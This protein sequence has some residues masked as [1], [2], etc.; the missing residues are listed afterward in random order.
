[1][2][3]KHVLSKEVKNMATASIDFTW[4]SADEKHVD[5]GVV[6]MRHMETYMGSKVWDSGLK[7]N[8]LTIIEKLRMKHCHLILSSKVNGADFAS[9]ST[10]GMSNKSPRKKKS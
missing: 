8:D 2:D 5:C 3:S 4:K 7:K 10:K 1:M 9:Q 6:L